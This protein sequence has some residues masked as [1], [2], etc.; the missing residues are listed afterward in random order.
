VKSTVESLGPTRVK[1]DVEVPF[2]ELKPSLDAAYK[3]IAKQVRIPGFRPGK[4]P[5]RIIDQRIGRAAVL[6]EAIN[7]A[8]PRAYGEAVRDSGVRAL[9]EPEI[10]VTKLDDGQS[11]SFTAQVDVRPEITLPSFDGIEVTVDDAEVTDAEVDEQLAELQD[12]FGTLKG[13]DRPVR[14]GDYIAID[15]VARVDGEEVEDGSASNLTY[16]VGSG[17]L[18]DGLDEAVTG[19]AAGESASFETTLR[20]GDHPGEQADVTVTVKSVKEKELPSADD[21]FAQLASE[22]DTLAELRDDLRERLHRV[23]IMTQAGQA[24]DRV[25]ERMLASV[26]VPLPESAVSAEV[27]NRE[28][29]IVHSLGHDDALFE[30][31]L[32]HQGKTREGFTEELRESAQ[33][34]V[35]AQFV[36]DAVADAEQIGVG[37]AE[38]TEYLIRQ[39]ARYQ[40]SP[41]EFADQ[42]V[43]AGNLPALVAD[44][45]RN[46]ALAQVLEHA[47]ITD[48]SGRPVD[49]AAVNQGPDQDEADAEPLR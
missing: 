49:L 34:S 47:V 40:V 11:L 12:R 43:E 13:V 31:L 21:D 7:A 39:A 26:D 6:E 46:K 24:R 16:T 22:F 44:V 38:L 30:Q 15:V 37:D 3:K 9:G 14:D 8:V 33:Q 48:A 32:V 20:A 36:L 42:I 29:E 27:G 25:L 35:K 5:S 28:H 18:I 1:L 4:A 23:K 17:D 45:R 41:K 19:R 2:D 10:E